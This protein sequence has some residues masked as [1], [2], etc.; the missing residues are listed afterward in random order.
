MGNMAVLCLATAR[1]LQAPSFTW[2][3]TLSP[4]GRPPP[5]LL[6]RR[7][8]RP[9]TRPMPSPTVSR[10]LH[11]HAYSTCGQ[12]QVPLIQLSSPAEGGSSIYCISV[13]STFPHLPPPC[14]IRRLLQPGG[15]AA[16]VPEPPAGLAPAAFLRAAI[17]QL[18]CMLRCIVLR[19]PAH[20]TQA[21]LA[22][23]F[24]C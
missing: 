21:L 12:S 3:H 11:V 23:H 10:R 13:Y 4:S 24:C 20:Q 8:P 17:H 15:R 16:R 2:L 1:H 9:P 22:A 6:P 5:S 7:L 14:S 18:P 19:Q